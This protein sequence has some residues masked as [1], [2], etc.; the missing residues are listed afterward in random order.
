MSGKSAA[1]L[2]GV[3]VAGLLIGGVFIYAAVKPPAQTATGSDT[4]LDTGLQAHGAGFGTGGAQMNFRGDWDSSNGYLTGDVVT[5]KGAAYV[6]SDDTKDQP[7][8]GPWVLL[9]DSSQG[10]PGPPGDPGPKGDKGDP[11]A[12]GADGGLAGFEIVFVRA[13]GGTKDFRANCPAGKVA[14]AGEV[15]PPNQVWDY[16]YPPDTSPRTAWAATSATTSNIPQGTELWVFC[17]DAP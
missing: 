13:P 7:P 15:F 4:G 16:P 17:A 10:P 6:T 12:A 14:I 9:V 3:F 1:A 11:G 5:F 2:I 8:N